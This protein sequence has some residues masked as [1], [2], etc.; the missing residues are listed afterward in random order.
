MP[1]IFFV[2]SCAQ[3]FIKITFCLMV[4]VE[5]GAMT[6]WHLLRCTQTAPL[7]EAYRLRRHVAPKA[8]QVLD[9]T[10][11]VLLHQM[12]WRRHKLLFNH[13]KNLGKFLKIN[14]L[15]LITC[16]YGI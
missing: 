6:F 9:G 13:L 7:F 10:K 16:F 15:K 8:L 14:P 5:I 2:S 4:C 11:R 3:L 1:I 12:N